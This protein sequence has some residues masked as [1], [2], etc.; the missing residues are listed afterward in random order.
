MRGTLGLVIDLVLISDTHNGHGGL[1]IPP[2]DVL[3]HAGDWSRHGT[4]EEAIPFFSW[5]GAQPAKVR[6]LTAGN[7]DFIAAQRPEVMRALAAQHGITWLIDEGV[8]VLGLRV[9]GSP[10]SPRH[11]EWAFQAERGAEIRSRWEL[12]PDGLDLLIT[13]TPPHGVLDLTVRDAHVGC[14]ELLA[15]V[16]ARPPQLHVFG[17]VHEAHGEL[18]LEGQA[19]RFVN[20]SSFVSTSVRRALSLEVR[21]PCTARLEPR[22]R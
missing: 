19:T 8:E 5:F 1:E 2:C 4:L 12:I 18:Q 15:A 10:Y 11:G 17:H 21:P 3:V 7:H 16:R 6:L 13:H 14:E 20:A 22:P 9:W